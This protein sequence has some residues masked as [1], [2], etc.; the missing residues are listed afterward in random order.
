MGTVLR[1]RPR[2]APCSRP[3]PACGAEPF[4]G[5][6]SSKM[7]VTA[8]DACLGS[9]CRWQRSGLGQPGTYGVANQGGRGRELEPVHDVRAMCLDRLETDAQ[10]FG[11]FLGLISLGDQLHD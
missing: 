5:G 3:W 6:G 8:R 9:S 10:D 11:D 4:L 2:S 1:T 7:F